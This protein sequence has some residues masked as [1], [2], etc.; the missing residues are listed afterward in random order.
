[1]RSD[2]RNEVA[3]WIEELYREGSLVKALD[4]SGQPAV[5]E[6]RQVY[7]YIDNATAADRDFW[8]EENRSH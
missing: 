3:E 7:K 2:M 8:H 5:F 4:A 1:M 6:G